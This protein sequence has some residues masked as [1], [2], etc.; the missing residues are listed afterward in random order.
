[1]LLIFGG[2][3]LKILHVWS[4]ADPP[5]LFALF[6]KSIRNKEEFFSVLGVTYFSISFIDAKADNTR[7][8]GLF[9]SFCFLSF[10]FVDIDKE[11]LPT[12]MTISN[13]LHK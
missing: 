11:S 9:T 3:L 1:M 6:P 13:F 2:S 5:I 10:H 7:L 4:N 8:I 12:G